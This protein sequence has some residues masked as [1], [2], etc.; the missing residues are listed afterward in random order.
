VQP[1]GRL[2]RSV[3]MPNIRWR[4]LPRPYRRTIIAAFI[5]MAAGAVVALMY[6]HDGTMFD[7]FLVA[8]VGM[9]VG[10]GSGLLSAAIAAFRKQAAVR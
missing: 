5:G 2:A 10:I 8:A 3:V 7:R 4:D 1:N 9:L 6:D